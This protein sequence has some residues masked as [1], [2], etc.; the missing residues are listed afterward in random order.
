MGDIRGDNSTELP[1]HE[2]SPQ[3]VMAEA[4]LPLRGELRR[5]RQGEAKGR[6]TCERSRRSP[7][8]LAHEIARR[9]ARSIPGGPVQYEGEPD[10]QD[11][12]VLQP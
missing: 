4:P 12:V 3:V 7:R 1:S 5:R 8:T 6:R 2:S 11:E 9:V 10:G